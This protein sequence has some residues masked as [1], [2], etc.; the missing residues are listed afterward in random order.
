MAAARHSSFRGRSAYAAACVAALGL[1]VVAPRAQDVA[2]PAVLPPTVA[3]ESA[4]APTA[5]RWDPR[6]HAADE[7]RAL[8]QAWIDARLAEAITLPATRGGLAVPALQFGAEGPIALAERPAILL[9]GGFDG[10]SLTGSE[11]VLAITSELLGKRAS[12]PKGVTF[13]AVPWA[14]PDALSDAFEGRSNGGRD[15]L[16]LDEDGDLAVDEDPPDDVDKD[17]LVL[18][19]I[20]EDP[21]GPYARAVDPRF[22]SPARS[23]DRP[24]YR[25]VREGRD[26]DG[27]GRFNED[28][29]GGV[30]LDVS[31]PVGWSAETAESDSAR[32]ARNAPLPLDDPLSRAIADLVLSRPTLAVLLFQGNHGELARP[33][34]IAATA[35]SARADAAV[36]DELAR[37]FAAATGRPVQTARAVRE[38]RGTDRRG[39]A[40]DWIHAVPGALALEIAAWGPEVERASDARDVGAAPARFENPESN[41]KAL[42]APSVTAVDRAWARWLDNTRGG[43]G[44]VDW[45]PVDLSDGT[46]A[47]V[48]GW[49]PF[50]RLNAPAASLPAAT[51]GMAAFVLKLAQGAPRLVI[52]TLEEKRDG[53]VL[54]L[55]WRVSNAGLLPTGISTLAQGRPDHAPRTELSLPPGARL[56]WG[57]TSAVLGDLAPGSASRELTSV[58]LTPKGSVLGLRATSG[59]TAPSVLEVKP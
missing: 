55:R 31:F 53:D 47:L 8:V 27:D 25:L 32:P 26:D 6:Y 18:D 5:P 20:V 2:P 12:L 59:W 3:P 29:I 10:Q 13:I 52:E 58:V 38:V 14:S 19:M 7:V 45:H 51:A 30:A 21:S 33:G 17:G 49:E 41:S 46:R 48:G 9:L 1:L 43:I 37:M 42:S 22:L 11:T 40:L 44:F 4:P 35:E 56:L 57:E 39:T 36:F 50:S 54:T 28:P 16:P 15:H 34:G 24:R 23:G